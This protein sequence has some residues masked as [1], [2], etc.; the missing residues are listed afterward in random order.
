MYVNPPEDKISHPF[1]PVFMQVHKYSPKIEA[2]V[3][4]SEK[5]SAGKR[6]TVVSRLLLAQDQRVEGIPRR[7]TLVEQFKKP[8][9]GGRGASV[10]KISRF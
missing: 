1:E 5:I 8:F 10:L 3:H 9:H 7:V 4:E 2:S 6:E